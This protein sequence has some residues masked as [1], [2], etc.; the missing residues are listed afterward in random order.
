M[1]RAKILLKY[2]VSNKEARTNVA[3]IAAG[4]PMDE[5]IRNERELIETIVDR[6]F[7][8]PDLREWRVNF[9]MQN[10]HLYESDD[11]Y[12]SEEEENEEEWQGRDE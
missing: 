4:D 5:E 6:S 10:D 7:P 11:S 8:D 9:I 2:E 1:A 3:A 12:Y